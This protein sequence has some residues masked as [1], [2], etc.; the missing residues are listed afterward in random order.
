MF[1]SYILSNDFVKDSTKRCFS[2]FIF[3]IIYIITLMVFI[4][5]DCIYNICTH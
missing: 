4:K 5:N 2:K 3:F 1:I